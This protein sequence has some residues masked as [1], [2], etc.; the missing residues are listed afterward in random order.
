VKIQN[1][2]K[3]IH[4]NVK[5]SWGSRSPKLWTRTPHYRH[6][7]QWI[8]FELIPWSYFVESSFSSVTRRCVTV[9]DDG[10]SYIET[11]NWR[12]ILCWW[13][14]PGTDHD[15]KLHSSAVPGWMER[16]LLQPVILIAY[17][18]SLS[19]HLWVFLRIHRSPCCIPRRMHQYTWILC[20]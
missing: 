19:Q 16:R 15:S 6:V 10:E 12:P 13:G 2:T 18:R 14:S 11:R 17:T 4:K 20:Q 1:W 9:L 3:S 5:H 8:I 7:Y